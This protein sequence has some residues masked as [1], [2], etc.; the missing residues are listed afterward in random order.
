MKTQLSFAILLCCLTHLFAQLPGELDF[1]FS[2]DGIVTTD[3]DFTSDAGYGIAVQEDG[4]IVVTGTVINGTD[5]D[6]IVVRYNADGSF[7]ASFA[8][9]GIYIYGYA[10]TGE[11]GNSV[12]I[13]SDGKIVVGGTAFNGTDDDFFL[14]LLE[15]NGTPDPAFGTSAG[16][17]QFDINGDDAVHDLAFD[18]DGKIL[19]GGSS[20]V[21]APDCALARFSA[22]GI[23]DVSFGTGGAL[24]ITGFGP[25][26][27]LLVD[28]AVLDDGKIAGAGI[29]FTGAG[30]RMAAMRILS[31]GTLDNTFSGNGIDMPDFG[32]PLEAAFTVMPLA[33]GK[34]LLAGQVLN[35]GTG[36]D[37]AF[38]Q[39]N[40][41]GTHDAGF[42]T[43]GMLS[44]DLTGVTEYFTGMIQQP[45]GKYLCGAYAWNG[46]NFD[47]MVS[48]LNPDLTPD[49]SFGDAGKTVFGVGDTAEYVWGIAMQP[50]GK[51]VIAGSTYNGSENDILVARLFSGLETSINASAIENEFSVYPN[52]AHTIIHFDNAES[53]AYARILVYD[54][55]G[56][57]VMDKI[58]FAITSMDLTPLPPGIYYLHLQDINNKS[59]RSQ[60]FVKE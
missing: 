38:V 42:G 53:G 4:K 21:S 49:E 19:T 27:D 23:P 18:A 58:G 7:D 52:P 14:T 26:S 1:T 16:Y 56:K 50:D 28:I 59:T 60:L 43:D 15:T 54:I 44:L 47:C 40:S 2:G 25:T 11:R 51:I 34:L 20:G 55:T 24:V 41:D 37:F 29:T 31:N 17:T 57:V 3:Y 5:Q 8:T 36:V 48:R 33:G 9:D 22:S 45:D 12:I 32:T 13:R 10:G 46:T 35:D 39:Y 6:L 30:N